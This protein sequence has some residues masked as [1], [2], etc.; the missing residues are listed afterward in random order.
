MSSVDD[1][2][3]ALRAA[4]EEHEVRERRPP[5]LVKPGDSPR[6][7]SVD[8]YSKSAAPYAREDSKPV[9]H[10]DTHVGQT[11]ESAAVVSPFDSPESA[12][13]ISPEAP[14]HVEKT[15][16]A[17]PSSL[18]LKGVDT[19][20]PIVAKDDDS[21]QPSA[22][23]SAVLE[24]GVRGKVAQRGGDSD[25]GINESM[26]AVSTHGI[27]SRRQQDVA[28]VHSSAKEGEDSLTP[29]Q[30]PEFPLSSTSEDTVGLISA[31]DVKKSPSS[32]VQPLIPDQQEVVLDQENPVTLRDRRDFPVSGQEPNDIVVPEREPES[33]LIRGKVSDIDKRQAHLPTDIAKTRSEVSEAQSAVN[34]QASTRTVE[35]DKEHGEVTSYGVRNLE[36]RLVRET[37]RPRAERSP[38]MYSAP[39]QMILR[40]ATPSSRNQTDTA[41]A[42]RPEH[43]APGEAREGLAT[44][45]VTVKEARITSTGNEMR[46]VRK[47]DIDT[48][49]LDQRVLHQVRT[50]AEDSQSSME[51]YDARRR[52]LSGASPPSVPD[53]RVLYLQKDG[54]VLSRT[55]HDALVDRKEISGVNVQHTQVS[56]RQTASTDELTLRGSTE[57][58][59]R[60][61]STVIGPKAEV[62]EPIVGK[63]SPLPSEPHE[64]KTALD[65]SSRPSLGKKL[66]KQPIAPT[67]Q[68]PP[69]MTTTPPQMLLHGPI[70]KTWDGTNT[71]LI[72]R[73]EYTVPGETVGG[74]FK[75]VVPVHAVPVT[76]EDDQPLMT[77]DPDI[78]IGSVA[79]KDTQNVRTI[80]KH[81]VE[82]FTPYDRESRG[83]AEPAP[84]TAPEESTRLRTDDK[85]SSQV[86]S[87]TPADREREAEIREVRSELA[88][89]RVG[90]ISEPAPAG[91]PDAYSNTL[92]TSVTTAA[93]KEEVIPV[94]RQP[95]LT[96]RDD[97]G[98]PEMDKASGPHLESRS[99]KVPTPRTEPPPVTDIPPPQMLLSGPLPNLWG[100]TDALI[101]REEY[102]VPGEVTGGPFSASGKA[103]S[104]DKNTTPD[105]TLT[106]KD[107]AQ[108][109]PPAS[110][111]LTELDSKPLAG[112]SANQQELEALADAGPH[113][114]QNLSPIE[115]VSRE[116]SSTERQP[117]ELTSV[118]KQALEQ[119][120]SQPP[121]GLNSDATEVKAALTNQPVAA[122]HLQPKWSPIEKRKQE[123][124]ANANRSQQPKIRSGQALGEPAEELPITAEKRE[125]AKP[126]PVRENVDAIWQAKW[127]PTERSSQEASPADTP[128]RHRTLLPKPTVIQPNSEKPIVVSSGKQQEI[129]TPP[130]RQLG[131]DLSRQPK[132]Y[133]LERTVQGPPSNVT[134][135]KPSS[136]HAMT[137]TPQAKRPSKVK[138]DRLRHITPPSQEIVIE[139]SK[140]SLVQAAADSGSVAAISRDERDVTPI[141]DSATTSRTIKLSD[142]LEHS[143]APLEM[144][145]APSDAT[146]SQPLTEASTP[147]SPDV[148]FGKT[149]PVSTNGSKDLMQFKNEEATGSPE[150]TPEEKRTKKLSESHNVEETDPKDG[151]YPTTEPKK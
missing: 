80:D 78:G 18:P 86:G 110:G 118:L 107:N 101:S 26:T 31:H 139:E 104:V 54:A 46:L 96:A 59:P 29:L 82:S 57:T 115:R 85:V 147:K 150:A 12:P 7:Q 91:P 132:W 49:D 38:A 41:L 99:V 102:T 44:D 148:F 138:A 146:S 123:F 32:L 5:Q 145:P 42:M 117:E 63:I 114:Q 4:A 50:S 75:E 6:K 69:V 124:L 65:D 67:M 125:I 35:T 88:G 16:V 95:L 37:V 56:G 70:P 34:K 43:K 100:G 77:Q 61:G 45:A 90:Q 108:A 113:Q 36:D 144:R 136:T 2:R 73:Q 122:S 24:G 33:Q 133:P 60:K 39:P 8:S 93:T 20:R 71:A 84:S 149:T 52:G 66:V 98:R 135:Q 30:P 142:K 121:A 92:Q 55:E 111:T 79:K 15:S 119:P 76:K 89:R 120:V 112:V 48:G 53:R 129:A 126:H 64:E 51:E 10:S 23:S 137:Q 19:A 47:S 103:P 72:S 62:Q 128:K 141:H 131:A 1:E 21:V 127:S 94:N 68:L 3:S 109:T 14:S 143:V 9:V 116:L 27:D 40:A 97:I 134:L 17:L 13:H 151:K 140:P 28:P 11:R 81:S 25:T 105:F 106:S 83:L 87:G 22:E 58:Y 130:S 74:P